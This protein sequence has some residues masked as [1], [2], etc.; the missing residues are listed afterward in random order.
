[1]VCKYA[2]DS[3]GDKRMELINE[4]YEI[5]CSMIEIMFT[6]FEML[7]TV[8]EKLLGGVFK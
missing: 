1:M 3:E 7:F 8:F 2:Y 6:A 4:I 5:F